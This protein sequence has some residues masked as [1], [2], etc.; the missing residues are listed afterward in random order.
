MTIDVNGDGTVLVPDRK[1][2]RKVMDE[3]F[4]DT[5]VT[6]APNTGSGDFEHPPSSTPVPTLIPER[7]PKLPLAIVLPATATPTPKA[8]PT[9]GRATPTRAAANGNITVRVYNGTLREHLAADVASALRQKGYS[10]GE[11]AQAAR[12]DYTET[13]I[14]D[15][16]GHTQAANAIAQ[17]L[18]VPT[19]AVKKLPPVADGV[20]ITV[21]LGSDA[22]LPR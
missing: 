7:E 4:S 9:T 21:V 14:R 15:H 17:L 8:T 13:I 19:T 12:V 22:Q 20:D 1:K 5:P 3:V 16:T 18:G 11:V 10:I 6:P 2:I